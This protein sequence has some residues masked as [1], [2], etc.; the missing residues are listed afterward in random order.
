[1]AR[2]ACWTGASR[3]LGR[4]DGRGRLMW[5]RYENEVPGRKLHNM[6]RSKHTAQSKQYVV[7][8]A[9]KIVRRCML[10]ATDPG[11]LVLDPTCGSGTTA[12]VAEKW[13]RRWITCDTSR[14]AIAIARKR[15]MTAHYDYY[16]LANP[17]QGVDGGF[18]HKTVDTHSAKTLAYDLPPTVVSLYDQPEIDRKRTRVTGP[19]TVEA[20][21][22]PT[23]MSVAVVLDGHRVDDDAQ[24][25]HPGKAKPAERHAD[26]RAELLKTG[27]RGRQGER[28]TF[29]SLEP[30]TGTRWLQATGETT[31][32]NSE[33]AQRVVVSFGPDYAPM[34]Q[35]QVELAMQEAQLHSP[36]PDLLVFA[37]FQF[38]P[39]ASKDIEMTSSIGITMLR[40]QM[41]PDLLTG[42]LQKNKAGNDSFWI[43]GQPDVAL[44]EADS[45]ELGD[46]VVQ[47]NGFDYFN[48]TTNEISSGGSSDIALWMLDTDYNGRCLYPRQ[49]FFPLG[50]KKHGWNPLAKALQATLDMDRIRA[51][52]G[53]RSLSFR[54]G[55][56]KQIAVKIID[57]RGVES[58]KVMEIPQVR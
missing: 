35:R 9:T 34:E 17:D 36:K 25:A 56:Y 31:E 24:P 49:V 53:T 40:T 29:T 1:M 43:I 20:V 45:G 13:G 18:V 7:Q 4:L 11:D 38:D 30:M 42:D 27:I 5:K 28:M 2:I 6:W 47:V 55:E 21:P 50:D 52:G 16:H 22:A 15:L 57:T 8:S 32:H 48:P 19:F 33:R 12:I 23:V 26:W 44:E 39:E 41:N 37:A 58:I 51:F 54:E 3:A 14:V 46:W 10:M